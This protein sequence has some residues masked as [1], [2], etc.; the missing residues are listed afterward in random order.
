MPTFKPPNSSADFTADDATITESFCRSHVLSNHCSNLET[1]PAT[2]FPTQQ[3]A[4][5]AP[6]STAISATISSADLRAQFTTCVPT[7]L[8]TASHAF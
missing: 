1:I 8:A 2:W 7:D 4:L 3:A 5:P 6:N